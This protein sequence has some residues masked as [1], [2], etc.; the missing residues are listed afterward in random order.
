MDSIGF[1]IAA[2]EEEEVNR[3]K[4]QKI[5]RKRLRD[6]CNPLDLEEQV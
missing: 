4:F 1:A 2:L 5:Y 3:K 6:A